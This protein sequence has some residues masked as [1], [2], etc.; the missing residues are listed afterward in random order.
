MLLIL[1]CYEKFIVMSNVF[2]CGINIKYFP[3][4]DVWDC[5]LECVVLKIL[6]AAYVDVS[7]TFKAKLTFCLSNIVASKL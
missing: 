2:V 3:Y 5:E 7:N 1:N 6:R 4:L